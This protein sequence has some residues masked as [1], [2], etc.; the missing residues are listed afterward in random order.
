MQAKGKISNYLPYFMTG[1]TL[2]GN[3]SL[4]SSLLDLNEFLTTSSSNEQA[5]VQ[6][7]TDTTSVG[8][9][10]VPE[11]LDL[12]LQT[13]IKKIFFDGMTLDNF[14]GKV[15]IKKGTATLNRISVDALGGNIS[16]NGSYSTALS[17]TSPKA[18]SR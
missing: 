2:S 5:D 14:T 12:S 10:V 4:T 1:E 18:A 9:L 16:A 17:T 3:L 15:S 11:D 7:D 8:V 13:D 6:E